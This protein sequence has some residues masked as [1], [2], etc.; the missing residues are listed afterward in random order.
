MH[1]RTLSPRLL[2]HLPLP[3]LQKECGEAAEPSDYIKRRPIKVQPAAG[4]LCYYADH[5][6]IMQELHVLVG[7]FSHEELTLMQRARQSSCII[8]PPT[9]HSRLTPKYIG[10]TFGAHSFVLV[11]SSLALTLLENI[12]VPLQRQDLEI[13]TT[14]GLQKT[15]S[16]SSDRAEITSHDHVVGRITPSPASETATTIRIDAALVKFAH[17]SCH[18]DPRTI[19]AVRQ[20]T[21]QPAVTHPLHPEP[22]LVHPL[23]NLQSY[24]LRTRPRRTDDALG[25]RR[26]DTHRWPRLGRLLALRGPGRRRC[27]AD[28]E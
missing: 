18:S 9:V 2:L 15:D 17:R 6:Q 27:A 10:L 25:H 23:R 7:P 22:D 13:A 5:A 3:H 8:S 19:N 16:G 26:R 24:G 4:S 1:A 11:L 21:S 28:A 14:V 12:I 20:R